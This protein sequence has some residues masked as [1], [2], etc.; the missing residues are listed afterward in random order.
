M[1]VCVCLCAK[2][3]ESIVLFVFSS[4]EVISEK[5]KDSRGKLLLAISS[6]HLVHMILNPNLCPDTFGMGDKFC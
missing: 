4:A 6:K 2:E 3:R 1:C 5:K